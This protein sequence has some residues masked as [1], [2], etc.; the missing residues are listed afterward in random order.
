MQIAILVVASL[1]TL[2]HQ[3]A[4]A[5]TSARRGTQTDTDLQVLVTLLDDD[6]IVRHRLSQETGELVRTEAFPLKGGPATLCLTPD[7]RRIHVGLRNSN[8]VATLSVGP[9]GKLA[10]EGVASL[11]FNPVHLVV[12]PTGK[13]LW[14]ASYVDSAWAVFPVRADGRVD[15]RALSRFTGIDKAHQIVLWAEEKWVLVPALG[16]DAVLIYEQERAVQEGAREPAHTLHLPKGAGPRHLVWHPGQPRFFVANETHSTVTMVEWDT[17]KRTLV[18]GPEVSS[19]PADYAGPNTCA[20]IKISPDGRHL[21]VSNRGHDSIAVFEVLDAPPGLTLKGNAPTEA[22]PR[23]F[24]LDPSARWLI[25]AGQD[26]GYMAL[27]ERDGTSGMLTKKSRVRVGER[28]YWV[29]IFAPV[30]V[31]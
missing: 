27:Y 13:Y 26:S 31:P 22:R 2:Y 6:V 21:Y 28:S 3:G 8:E 25:A 29:E 12:G 5:G 16:L 14:A 20:Q 4:W 1:L 11:G 18:A 15:P 7:R 23:A 24:G 9:D 10:L 19:L 17:A 30:G